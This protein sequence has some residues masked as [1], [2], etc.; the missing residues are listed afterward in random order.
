MCRVKLPISAGDLFF[1][2]LFVCEAEL[3]GLLLP[4]LSPFDL[5]LDFGIFVELELIN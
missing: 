3:E 4:L 5:P 2:L 1:P